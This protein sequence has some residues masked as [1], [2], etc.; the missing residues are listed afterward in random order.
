MLPLFREKKVAA[1]S[2]GLRNLVIFQH[3]RDK[4]QI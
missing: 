4:D 2:F 1:A 3:V